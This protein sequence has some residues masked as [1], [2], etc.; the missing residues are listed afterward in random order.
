MRGP[1]RQPLHRRVWPL[2]RLAAR[3]VPRLV[4]ALVAVLAAA[5]FVAWEAVQA[6]LST[7]SHAGILSAIGVLLVLALACGH[8]RQR[9]R[10]RT[11]SLGVARALRSVFAAGRVR[12]AAVGGALVWVL[13]I[14]ATAGWDATSFSEQRH[15]L[16]TLSRLFGDVTDHDWGRALLFAAWLALG[17]YLAT[18]WRRRSRDPAADVDHA[19]GRTGPRPGGSPGEDGRR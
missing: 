7:S 3:P 6:R 17:A 2:P 4:A 8:G 14:A 9:E 12:T 10:S 1:G 11:W 16:P 5:A 15:D 18:G 13:L 19:N